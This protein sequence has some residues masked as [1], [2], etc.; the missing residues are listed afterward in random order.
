MKGRV[1]Q[2]GRWASPRR[3]RLSWRLAAV[4]LVGIAGYVLFSRE[5]PPGSGVLRRDGVT[6]PAFTPMPQ[7][8]G[9]APRLPLPP[10]PRGREAGGRFP[11]GPRGADS[12]PPGL[13]RGGRT[14]AVVDLNTAPLA[15]LQTLPGITPDYARKIMAGR[16]YRS[17][18]EVVE[19]TGIPQQVV[20][21]I[22]PPAII[23]VVEGRSS[24][25]PDVPPVPQ[26]D[27]QP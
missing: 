12:A 8:D 7:R 1:L 27:R 11:P 23:R 10:F 26:R 16:P 3:W 14:V 22:S 19:H 21:Q 18:R 2:K 6:A 9:V 15:A 4:V 5:R 20:D 25:D 17:F 13:L 24:L